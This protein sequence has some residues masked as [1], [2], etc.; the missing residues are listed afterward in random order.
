[1]SEYKEHTGGRLA[2]WLHGDPEKMIPLHREDDPT[3]VPLAYVGVKGHPNEGNAQRL[4][5][6]WNACEGIPTEALDTGVVQDMYEALKA[7]VKLDEHMSKC[8]ECSG[9]EFCEEAAKISDEREALRRAA[10]SKA[11]GRE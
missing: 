2:L 3:I 4:V 10:L 1:M 9:F 6:A 11:E 7:E 5:A 8:K